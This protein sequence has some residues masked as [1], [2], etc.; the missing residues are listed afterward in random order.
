VVPL[1]T[2]GA[3]RSWALER[4]N[5]HLV[6][7]GHNKCGFVPAQGAGEHRGRS[8][9]VDEAG[10][11][12]WTDEPADMDRE[13][14]TG[15]LKTA[16]AEA[17]TGVTIARGMPFFDQ[18]LWLLALPEFCVLTARQ[19]AIDQHLVIPSERFGTPTL[20]S[21]GSL[22]YRTR[23]PVDKEDTAFELGAY[24]H[25]PHGA[26]LAE[27]LAG[28]IRVWGRDHRHGPG[29]ALTVHPADAPASD[30]PPGHLIDKRHTTVVLSWPELA[31]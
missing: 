13:A 21:G 30:L 11:G 1:R 8:I 24:G 18:D 5:G 19:D 25:G 29:P 4:E 12:L 3:T 16:R 22:A 14:L 20:A 17:W 15:V 9:P 26:E 23:R 7:R 2:R 6:S 10:V 31:R 28:Q 27:R